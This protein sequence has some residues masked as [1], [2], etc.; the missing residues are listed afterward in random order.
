[1]GLHNI[2]IP[3][4]PVPLIT[5]TFLI[6]LLLLNGFK[7]SLHY[8]FPAGYH[9]TVFQDG[10][11]QVTRQS[12]AMQQWWNIM[13]TTITRSASSYIEEETLTDLVSR[14]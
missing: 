1:M 7:E 8:G 5:T 13:E 2:F 11:L 3:C 9:V 14:K 6:F 4:R 12:Q 10:Q